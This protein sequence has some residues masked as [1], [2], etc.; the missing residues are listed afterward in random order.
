MM[1]EVGA[2]DGTAAADCG[3][4]ARRMQVREDQYA[5]LLAAIVADPDRPDLARCLSR[6]TATDR[7]LRAWLAGHEAADAY[8][9]SVARRAYERGRA[10][11]RAAQAQRKGRHAA[12]PAQRS[13]FPR[14]V[15]GIAGL[16]LLAKLSL[17][18]GAA[19][20]VAAGGAGIA[21]HTVLAHPSAAA[22][23]PAAAA[24]SYDTVATP[25]PPPSSSPAALTHPKVDAARAGQ[26]PVPVITLPSF[27]TTPA[28]SASPPAPSPQ[29]PAAG[30]LTAS[31][32]FIDLGAGDLPQFAITAQ[33]GRVAWAANC[34]GQ[35]LACSSTSGLLEDGGTVTVGITVSPDALLSG[36]AAVIIVDPGHIRV[37]VT[38]PAAPVPSVSD[39]PTPSSS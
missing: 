30:T 7:E 4:V 29:P 39:T 21:A 9:E 11:E 32:T 33:G 34:T 6:Q 10:D 12:V 20:V 13:F 5:A 36:G 14:L 18:F 19:A 25:L 28:A 27:A 2:R 38:W 17:G 26:L 8:A 24:P 16:P 31:T 37:T 3:E 23:A 22:A 35:V 1:P 15:Q